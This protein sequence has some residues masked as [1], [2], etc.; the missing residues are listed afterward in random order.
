[1]NGVL[2][3]S[4]LLRLA[5]VGY[6][7]VLLARSSDRRFGFLTVMLSLMATRQLLSARSSTTPVEELPGLAVSVLALLTV[8]YLSSYVVEE[9]RVTERLQGFRK[10]IEHAG[11]AIFVTD[12]D[13][14]IEYANPAVESVVGY[15]PE[16]VVGENP[17]LWQS[18]EHDEDFYTELWERISSGEVWEG[19]IVNRRKSGEL[20]WVD[21]TVAPITDE[22]GAVE[23]YVAVER[24][25]TDRKE[26]RLRIE[27][28]NDRL[29]RLNNTNEVLRDVNRELV[30]ASTRREIER[31]LCDRF[32]RSH[33][34]DAA[35]VG[36]PR[37]V[38][39][40]V[41]VQAAAG[42]DPETLETR[43]DG[44]T[45]Y[46]DVAGDVLE[47]R[48]PALVDDD[49]GPVDDPAGAAGVVV[50]LSY[51]DA[52]YGALF[53]EAAT[54]GAFEAIDRAVFAELGLTVGDAIN[55]AESRRTLASDEVTRLEF[56]LDGTDDPLVSLSAALGCTIELD[57][58]GDGGEGDCAAY[59][60]VAGCEPGPVSAHAADAPGVE[61]AE[62]LC[63][64]DGQCAVRLALDDAV[65]TTLAQYGAAVQ[66][67]TV[68]EGTGRLV[69]EVA[70]SNDVR[71]VVEAV[72]SAY[73]GLDLIAQREREPDAAA[74]TEFRTTFEESLTDRQLEA[75]QTAYFAGFFEWPRDASGE[76]VAETMGINQSTFT[77]HL[78][79]AERKLFASLFDRDDD[80]VAEPVS[81]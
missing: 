70:R 2:V 77:Q 39:D 48:R 74:E 29:E 42:V 76:D 18:G 63:A 44:S 16:E 68:T 50:P 31:V 81:A 6:S 61:R 25:V 65:V 23:H 53:V 64:G 79:A 75:A 43:L 71:S 37:L 59:V 66:S 27:E 73:P 17:R 45:A 4:V 24:D 33:L 40:G 51:Q 60:S 41:A 72:Q 78:R 28:Q 34:F 19:E 11:H 80:V 10:A 49:G 54:D 38:D 30:G 35:W 3:A 1:M 15:G 20:C 36:T 12:A 55:A 8:Y 32:A 5:G 22:A 69:A 67:L 57:R 52:D 7:L 21:T 14:T 13:G 26:R 9:R 62:V 56:R 47:Q 46:R 58:I